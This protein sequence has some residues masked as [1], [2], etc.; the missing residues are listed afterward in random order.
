MSVK[1]LNYIISFKY[2][3][4]CTGEISEYE[5]VIEGLELNRDMK[6]PVTIRQQYKRAT[7]KYRKTDTIH[8]TNIRHLPQMAQVIILASLVCCHHYCKLTSWVCQGIPADT[9]V[10]IQY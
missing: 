10:A 4:V 9:V 5:I 2:G 6:D 7:R 1:R 3:E 8:G